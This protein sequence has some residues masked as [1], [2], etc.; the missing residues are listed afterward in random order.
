M[1]KK[2]LKVTYYYNKHNNDFIMSII[3][4]KISLFINNFCI[5]IFKYTNTKFSLQ[6][7]QDL[8]IILLDILI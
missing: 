7:Y 3:K 6:V 4:Y 2:L 1:M 8:I 5:Y